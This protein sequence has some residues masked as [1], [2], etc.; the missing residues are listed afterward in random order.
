MKNQ[1]YEE[2]YRFYLKGYSLQEVAK[3]FGLTRQAVYTGFKKKRI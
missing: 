2:M 3:Q 1:L